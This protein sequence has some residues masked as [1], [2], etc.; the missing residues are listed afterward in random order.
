MQS[1]YDPIKGRALIEANQTLPR[2]KST[3]ENK[4]A[5]KD[6]NPIVNLGSKISLAPKHSHAHI[7]MSDGLY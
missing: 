2:E 7:V 3:S 4:L 1:D 5:F 6:L